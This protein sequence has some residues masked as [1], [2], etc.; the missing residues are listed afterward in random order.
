MKG[1]F[2]GQALYIHP[3]KEIVIACYNYV[4]KDWDVNNLISETALSE[5]IKAA[6]PGK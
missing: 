3:E 1:G 2:G 5:I 6:Q 4:D